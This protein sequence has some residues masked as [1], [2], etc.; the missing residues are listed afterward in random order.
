MSPKPKQCA[1]C[2]HRLSDKNIMSCCLCKDNYDL[3]CACIT[4][5]RF[6]AMDKEAKSSWSCPGC[7]SK[8]KKGDNTNTPV[9]LRA[10]EQRASSVEASA[11][12]D[13]STLSDAF[14]NVTH[15]QKA[16]SNHSCLSFEPELLRDTLRSMFNDFESRVELRLNAIESKVSLIQQQNDSIKSTNIDIEKSISD[17]SARI[18]M[19]QSTIVRIEDERKQLSKQI[20]KLEDKC[21][22]LEKN[23]T[24]TCIEIRNVPKAKGESKRDLY[25]YSVN[26]SKVLNT[27]IEQHHIRDIHRLPNKKE[28]ETS[29]ILIEVTNTYTKNNILEACKKFYK[30]NN[31][32]LSA[33]NLG[34]ENNNTRI[35]ISEYLTSKGRRLFYLAKALKTDK[36][37]SYC[38]TAGGNVYLRK[39]DGLPA[40][41]VKSE[42]QLVKLRNEL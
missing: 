17:V 41:L 5:Q 33:S 19:V 40:I 34:F 3:A 30:S 8:V 23:L 27:V 21:E 39:A 1:G 2:L 42:D 11:S 15:R 13:F 24:K 14:D 20:L 4:R 32:Q 6:N 31:Y 18:E 36:G 37:F 35:F 29:S 9:Q 28:N 25:S 12:A 10:V 38:W 22:S 26:L 7:R 16:N